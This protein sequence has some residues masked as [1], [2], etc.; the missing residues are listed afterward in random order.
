MNKVCFIMDQFFEPEVAK[1]VIAD[2]E[3]ESRMDEK[4]AEGRTGTG[5]CKLEGRE[6]LEA[7]YK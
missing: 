1:E 5:N 4:M 6:Q 3:N 7:E 2:K